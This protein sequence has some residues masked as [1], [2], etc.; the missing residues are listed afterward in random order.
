MRRWH[1]NF[2]RSQSHFPLHIPE[3]HKGFAFLQYDERSDA[4]DAIDN[5]NG[6][7]LFGRVLK[8]NIAKADAASRGSHR[9][10]WETQAD[11]FFAS[12]QGEGGEK[13]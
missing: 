13:E 10:I 8:V 12:E 1:A 7:E 6:A 3:K 4:A 9:P 11:N 2:A 5:M